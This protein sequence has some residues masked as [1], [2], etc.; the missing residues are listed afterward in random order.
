MNLERAQGEP[1]C[2]RPITAIE[3]AKL[4][5]ELSLENAD[6]RGLLLEF[7]HAHPKL[8]PFRGLAGGRVVR[9]QSGFAHL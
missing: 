4:A 7:A 9:P 8:I 1:L 3:P 6:V 5:F 2:E